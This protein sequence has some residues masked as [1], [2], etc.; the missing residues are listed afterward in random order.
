MS[1]AWSIEKDRPDAIKPFVMN[2]TLIRTAGLGT[3]S[4][5]HISPNISG[6]ASGT[7]GP[8][9][10]WGPNTPERTLAKPSRG[11]RKADLLPPGPRDTNTNSR[12]SGDHPRQ[13]RS[14]DAILPNASGA[15]CHPRYSLRSK[16][17]R[18][19]Q[20]VWTAQQCRTSSVAPSPQP[21]CG[22]DCPVLAVAPTPRQAP[23]E[24]LPG[25]RPAKGSLLEETPW[26]STEEQNV[27][28]SFYRAASLTTD[29]LD[30]RLRASHGIALSDYE[31]LVHLSEAHGRRLRM[32]DLAGQALLSRSRLTFRVDRLVEM[33]FV[34][35]E[36]VPDDR[37]GSF[38]VITD[39]GF[40]ALEAAAPDHVRDVREVVMDHI[41]RERLAAVGDSTHAML[42]Y[43]GDW[44]A[45]PDDQGSAAS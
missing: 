35:R 13:K 40:A 2:S 10:V 3:F 24:Q 30:S 43:L 19:E 4:W 9:R 41:G 8:R 22:C 1:A 32:T 18:F 12:P 33:G 20:N 37:R 7:S 16:T 29:A 36:A 25:R 15:D 21:R 34:K 6:T 44:F 11:Q 39:A 45:T 17:L 14:S 28:R 38:A 26:L 5:H 31:I 23:A 42:E 27:W